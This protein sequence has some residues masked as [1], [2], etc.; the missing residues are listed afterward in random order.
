MSFSY[1]LFLVLLLLAPGFS[2][3]AGLRLA[4]YNELVSQAPE[5]P[6]STF[7]LLTI[8]FGAVAGHFIMS[9]LLAAQE[10]FCRLV[11]TCLHVRFDPN[12]YRVIVVGEQAKAGSNSFADLPGWSVPYWL[13]SL[14]LPAVMT[15]VIAFRLGS[16]Q[17]VRR[18]R[19]RSVLGW[20]QPWIAQARSADQFVVAYVVTSM[21][22]DGGYV[23]YEGVLAN[24]ALDDNRAIAMIV[25]DNCD[26]FLV[27]ITEDGV[28]RV[29][30]PTSIGLI[31]LDARNCLNIALELFGDP[32]AIS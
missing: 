1:A 31:Q 21:A 6:N 7:S 15:G 10:T 12:I 18:L 30:A 9:T 27:K 8:V 11:T 22:H 29:D 14:L 17:Q 16:R 13:L 19:E 3:W 32:S 28:K 25:L 26:R 2:V 23:A 4:E 24:V 5:R 20:F